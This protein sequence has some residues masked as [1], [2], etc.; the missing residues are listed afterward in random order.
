[1]HHRGI[2]RAHC[3]RGA[4]CLK[5]THCLR[6][7]QNLMTHLKDV[8]DLS[9][10]SHQ[11]KEPFLLCSETF[12]KESNRRTCCLS[13]CPNKHIQGWSFPNCLAKDTE[14]DEVPHTRSSNGRLTTWR[15]SSRRNVAEVYNTRC[16][17][18][19]APAPLVLT[20]SIRAP[21]NTSV[22]SNTT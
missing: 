5:R 7:K 3:L 20:D 2:R 16:S 14:Q 12:S 8:G 18:P 22:R 21:C 13:R 9:L 4:H 6:D 11:D 10:R 17:E 19:R 1:M 15:R